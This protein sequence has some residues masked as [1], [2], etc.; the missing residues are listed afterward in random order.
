MEGAAV[1]AVC[2]GVQCRS[3][4][5]TWIS[6]AHEKFTSDGIIGVVVGVGVVG[7]RSPSGTAW[8]EGGCEGCMG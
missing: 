8:D 1:V 7:S 4:A 2:E 6:K 5:I 3:V